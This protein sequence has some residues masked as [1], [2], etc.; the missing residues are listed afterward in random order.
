[1]KRKKWKGSEMCHFCL[2]GESMDHL[3]FRCPL[4]IYIWALI[5][6]E[7]RWGPMLR[8]VKKFV[9]DFMFARGGKRNGKLIFVFRAIA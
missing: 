1:V 4:A 8:G 7:L 3:L 9:E 5:R 2:E 6:D